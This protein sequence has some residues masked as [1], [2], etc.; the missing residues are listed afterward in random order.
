[1]L[2]KEGSD[3]QL[4][5]EAEDTSNMKTLL[6]LDGKIAKFSYELTSNVYIRKKKKRRK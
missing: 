6:I 2:N 1:M 5:S 4:D 3:F